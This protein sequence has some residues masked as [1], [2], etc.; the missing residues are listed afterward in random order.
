MRKQGYLPGIG[1]G[2]HGHGVAEFPI[3]L[4]KNFKFGLGYTPTTEDYLEKEKFEQLK[5]RAN[6]IGGPFPIKEIQPYPKTLNS[7]FV[8]EGEN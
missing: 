8:K 2:S 3:H 6:S 1:I 7:Q 5:R 4:I